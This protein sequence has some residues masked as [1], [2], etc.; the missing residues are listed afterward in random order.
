[1]IPCTFVCEGLGGRIAGIIA[2]E[3]KIYRQFRN[4]YWQKPDNNV[5]KIKMMYAKKGK[6]NWKI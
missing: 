1:M 2:F 3:A 4:N 5:E 6:E